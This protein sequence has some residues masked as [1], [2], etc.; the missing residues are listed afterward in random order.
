VG[1][2]GIIEVAG[3]DFGN[4]QIDYNDVYEAIYETALAR[5]LGPKERLTDEKN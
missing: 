3:S 1:S 4:F 2:H 5:E